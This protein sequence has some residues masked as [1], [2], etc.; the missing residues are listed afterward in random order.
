MSVEQ[1]PNEEKLKE[2]IKEDK[3]II[4][5]KKQGC[6]FC[7]KAYPWLEEISQEIPEKKIGIVDK[8]D[9]PNLFEAFNLVMYPT[10]LKINK[11]IVEDTFYGDTQ[12]DKVKDFIN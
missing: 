1:I 6:P 5:I 12:Y 11:G 2:F 3:S 9:I 8:D 7:E 4:M 10:F